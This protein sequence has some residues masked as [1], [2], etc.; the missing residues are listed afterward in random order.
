V[1]LLTIPATYS[2]ADG[3]GL[4]FIAY[5]VIQVLTGKPHRVH[6]VLYGTAA[7]FA[8]YFIWAPGR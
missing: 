6:P 2:I 4:G 1:T 8:A 3:V 7:A 5:V